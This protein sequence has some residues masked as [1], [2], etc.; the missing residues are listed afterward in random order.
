M[1]ALKFRMEQEGLTPGDLEPL[2]GPSGPVFEVLKRKWPHDGLITSYES[3][4]TGVS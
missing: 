3:V 2:I 4:L 1:E